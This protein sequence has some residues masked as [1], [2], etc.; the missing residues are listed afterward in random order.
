MPLRRASCSPRRSAASAT[1]GTR[2]STAGTPS[3]PWG[4]EIHGKGAANTYHPTFLYEFLW[5]GLGV[6]LLLWV[7]RRFTLRRPALFMLYVAYYTSF[8]IYEETL[9]I[10][11]SAHIG[12]QR[13]NFWVAIGVFVASV[14][15]FIWWQF[16]RTPS[17]G[18][19]GS[20][21]SLRRSGGAQGPKMAVPVAASGS[22]GSVGP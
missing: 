2:S 13:L 8:R 9:R 21:E 12:G 18:K 22:A 16:V 6:L 10:D 7:D 17:D 11:P 1:T 20:R 15:C 4:L 14:T 3:L 19:P 5:D